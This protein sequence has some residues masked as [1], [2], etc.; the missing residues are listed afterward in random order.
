MPHGCYEIE[1]PCSNVNAI[2]L[3]N[4]NYLSVGAGT[5]YSLQFAVS[6]QW[7]KVWRLRL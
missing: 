3:T 7:N 5:S 4:V 6:T 1:E 2:L